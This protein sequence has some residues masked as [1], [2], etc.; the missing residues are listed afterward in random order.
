[1]TLFFFYRAI[2]YESVSLHFLVNPIEIQRLIVVAVLLCQ[3]IA[4][5]TVHVKSAAG[6]EGLECLYARPHLRGEAL[7]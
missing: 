7:N 6:Y 1:M 2:P 5:R 4:A 3:V